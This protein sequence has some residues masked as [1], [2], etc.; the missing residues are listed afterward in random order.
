MGV[1]YERG[2][3]H[4]FLLAT[5]HRTPRK[6][7]AGALRAGD[8]M[9]VIDRYRGTWEVERCAS[10]S[11]SLAGIANQGSP[12][13]RRASVCSLVRRDLVATAVL[14][15]AVAEIEVALLGRGGTCAL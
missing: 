13:G 2:R 12:A 10:T 1:N 7:A 3:F 9:F 15:L 4:H 14:V 11:S 8:V 5:T 6:A